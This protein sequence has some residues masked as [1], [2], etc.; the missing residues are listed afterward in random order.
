[1]KYIKIDV[2]NKEVIDDGSKCVCGMIEIESHS[3]AFKEEI[4]GCH[5]ECNCCEYCSHQ[6]AMDI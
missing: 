4:N 6:C 2:K 1:M 5:D 3:C